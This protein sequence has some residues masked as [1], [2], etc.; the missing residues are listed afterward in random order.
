MDDVI[1]DEQQF[2]GDD[3]DQHLEEEEDDAEMDEVHP[4]DM[5]I[6]F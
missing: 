2:L 4:E 1:Q 3:W 6:E 5:E